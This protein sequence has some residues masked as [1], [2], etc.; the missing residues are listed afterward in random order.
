MH[1]SSHLNTALARNSTGLGSETGLYPGWVADW[2]LVQSRPIVLRILTAVTFLFLFFLWHAVL[3]PLSFIPP[4]RVCR[5]HAVA[6]QRLVLCCEQN[7]KP[8]SVVREG[9]LPW[10]EQSRKAFGSFSPVPRQLGEASQI[11]AS[12]PFFFF[13]P[14]NG[15]WIGV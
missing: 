15:L 1:F 14:P 5:Y 11:R 7:Q 6:K 2:N 13:N 10:W 4:M 9:G 12:P 3:P 8:N